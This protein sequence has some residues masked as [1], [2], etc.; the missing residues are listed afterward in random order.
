[1]C[2][3][4]VP[5]LT[6]TYSDALIAWGLAVVLENV[7]SQAKVPEFDSIRIKDGGTDFLVI[8]PQS[9]QMEWL[10]QVSAQTLTYYIAQNRDK[11]AGSG[12]VN[13]IFLSEEYD[14]AKAQDISTGNDV[15]LREMQ[16]G[17]ESHRFL[18]H[19]GAM[20]AL[21]ADSATNKVYELTHDLK[22]E[23]YHKLIKLLLN[24]FGTI[25]YSSSQLQHELK[26]A[27]LP[28]DIITTCSLFN[29]VQGKGDNRPKPEGAKPKNMN[30][31]WVYEWL[32][33]IGFL[34]SGGAIGFKDAKN[35]TKEYRIV[36]L[37]PRSITLKTHKEVFKSF[38]PT[39]R[40]KSSLK[41]D[42]LAGLL[43]AEQ[44]LAYIE[45]NESS[46]LDNILGLPKDP[47]IRDAVQGF[48]CAD[49]MKTSQ[50]AYSVSRV[51][52]H[53][54]P[55]WVRLSSDLE[56][57]RR[58]EQILEEHRR[59][60]RPLDERR[61]EQVTLLERYRDWLSSGSMTILLDFLG[62][63]AEHRMRCAGEDKACAA[64]TIPNLEVIFLNNKL[65]NPPLL[66]ILE[67][68]GFRN[69]ATAI[70]KG[71]INAQYQ[72]KNKRLPSGIDVHFELSHELR[73]TAPYRDKF[74]ASLCDYLN[75]Y[76]LE[77]LR[78]S[79]RGENPGRKNIE[80][81]D[82]TQ[83]ISLID[84][85]NSSELIC[86]LLLAFGYARDP[87]DKEVQVAPSD[88]EPTTETEGDELE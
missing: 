4:Y 12:G 26:S 88:I 82:I 3:Y 71:T 46:D 51:T 83:I 8:L 16:A 54:L 85:Y 55:A 49:F 30:T 10:Q 31:V 72:R 68:E 7:M 5:K 43:Y 63:Y 1:M 59:C 67:N 75:I 53:D 74:V 84:E 2:T 19:F 33:T 36:V 42:C 22:N 35:K 15:E 25:N 48:Q 66:P 60:V 32:K 23:D 65:H 81:E 38:L 29:P 62:R 77:N 69:I 41:L 11:Y 64:F 73:R 61:G 58:Y 57:V 34:E 87:R 76:N 24:T 37:I 45:T 21:Q 40:A 13:V 70:R 44:F 18:S 20:N 39:F 9:F 17:R 79:S 80:T 14:R 78:V 47:F 27:G 52:G 86:G 6:D 56:Q 50:F 28:T